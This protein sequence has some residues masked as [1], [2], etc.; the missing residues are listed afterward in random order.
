V[1]GAAAYR[2]GRRLEWQ[3][4]TYLKMTGWYVMRSPRS[5]GPV[6]VCAIGPGGG[7]VLFVQCRQEGVLGVEEWNALITLAARYGAL[8]MVA[9]AGRPLRWYQLLQCK[10]GRRGCKQPWRPV[11][12]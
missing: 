5:A 6:D 9:A 8:P 1:N 11:S 10:T 2:K 12:L 7:P 3:V 4:A